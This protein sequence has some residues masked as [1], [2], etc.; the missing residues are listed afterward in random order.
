MLAGD[1]VN[2]SDLGQILGIGLLAGAGLVA[3]YSLGL[4]LLAAGGGLGQ[5]TK[6]GLG[7]TVAV[8]GAVVCFLVVLGGVAWGIDVM[9]AK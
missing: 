1:Y 7:G 2:W 6:R 9:L 8:I 5:G 4:R 3:V